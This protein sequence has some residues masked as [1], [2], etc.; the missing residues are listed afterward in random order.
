MSQIEWTDTTWNPIIGCSR[1]SLGCDHC[2]AIRVATRFQNSHAHYLGTAAKLDWTGR[3]N[4]APP[5]IFHKPRHTRKPTV[6][7]VN[8]M[9]DLFHEGVPEH[10]I[11]EVFAIMNE[12]PQHE[13]QLLTKRPQ[14]ALKKARELGLRFTDNIWM[15][16]TIEDDKYAKV[17]V[18][19][20]AKMKREFA[21]E[22]TFVSA[23]PLLSDLPSLPVAE[24]DW[25]IVGGESG[26]ET[27]VH[28][29][30][31]ILTSP[32]FPHFKHFILFSRCQI[33]LGM[34]R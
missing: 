11:R 1:V 21:I 25:L 12:T 16:A 23:E 20:L 5:H 24:I 34:E 2:Y 26:I 18:R 6:W 10:A 27:T 3:I 22:T 15:G 29:V 7:F 9:S 30:D 19:A 4:V 32:R 17:R 13:Y 31:P 8:S 33:A 28:P 14:R